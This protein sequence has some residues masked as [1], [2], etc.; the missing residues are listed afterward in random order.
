MEKIFPKTTITEAP[1]KV[2]IQR[3][4]INGLKDINKK[5]VVFGRKINVLMNAREN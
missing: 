1:L 2:M 5:V 4:K 3:K